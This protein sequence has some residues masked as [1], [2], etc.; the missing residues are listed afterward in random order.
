MP[1]RSFAI[2]GL[3]YDPSTDTGRFVTGAGLIGWSTEAD[4]LAYWQDGRVVSRRIDDVLV[5]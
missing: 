2:K 4:Q 1:D 5:K 3:V